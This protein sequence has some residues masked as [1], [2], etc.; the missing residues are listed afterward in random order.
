MIV[1]GLILLRKRVDGMP[2]QKSGGLQH[3]LMKKFDLPDY[4]VI[5]L[6]WKYCKDLLQKDLEL[7]EDLRN[8]YKCFK[9]KSE[10]SLNVLYITDDKFKQAEKFL[11]E[12]LHQTKLVK[13][14][15]KFY[16]Q[17]IEGDVPSFKQF[18][19][20]SEKFFKDDPENEISQF[21]KGVEIPDEE[22]DEI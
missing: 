6:L 12:R 22:I 1:S 16:E 8:A 4:K 19:A 2:Y 5:F 15:N 17:A 14:Y 20:F 9:S 7:Y 3:E 10:E 21:L 13:L 18:S 11:L